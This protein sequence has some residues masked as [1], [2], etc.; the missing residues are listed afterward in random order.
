[1]ARLDWVDSFGSFF[2]HFFL[3]GDVV[4]RQVNAVHSF[5]FLGLFMV[6]A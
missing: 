3:S 1:M 4:F 6:W 2:K 5:I